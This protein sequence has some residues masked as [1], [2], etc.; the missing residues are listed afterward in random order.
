MKKTKSVGNGEGSLCF[1]K[2]L[3]K[4]EYYYNNLDGERKV[5]R[6]KKKESVKDFK[7]RVTEIKEK[8]NKGTYIEKNYETI[9]SLAEKFIIQKLNNKKTEKR[10]YRRDLETIGQIKKTCADFCDIPIQKVTIDDIENAKPKMASQY[11]NSS[12]DKMW[13]LLRKVFSIASSPTRRILAVN[14][15]LD[16]NL[17]KPISE[18][19]FRKVT[20]LSLK[21]R[22]KLIHVLDNDERTHKYRNILK[23]QLVSA[24][25]IGEVLAR[26]TSDFNRINDTLNVHNTLTED[27]NYN[28]IMG[29]HTKTYNKKT[30]IDE[31]QRYIPLDA[32]MFSELKQLVID[33]SSKRITNMYGLLFWDYED[34]TFITPK[35][36]NSYLDRIN[37]KYK[38]CKEKLS[39]HRLRHTTI[40]YWRHILKIPMEVIQ[41]LVGHVEESDVTAESYIDTSFEMVKHHL[42]AEKII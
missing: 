40:T 30:Q 27:E 28:V 24:M 32:P 8:L 3:N 31:G 2:S 15:M 16:E 21:E 41:Y 19:P 33:E 13:T 14:I 38:I 4:W 11:S 36:I 25:R 23:M 18:K 7:A 22:E 35:E 42:N 26:S 9:I 12:I 6:Q 5:I 17:E 37:N 10:T 20:A 39:S 29:E 34:N 1:S